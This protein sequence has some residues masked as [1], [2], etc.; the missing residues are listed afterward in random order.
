MADPQ[1]EK[2]DLGVG[3][4]DDNDSALDD[5]DSDLDTSHEKPS[6]KDATGQAAGDD[7][8]DD[9]FGEDGDD[10][11]DA[12]EAIERFGREL[13]D[14]GKFRE[15][16]RRGLGRLPSLQRDMQT[17]KEAISGYELLAQQFSILVEALGPSLDD[18]PRQRLATLI[19]Q[20]RI[21]AAVAKRT[22]SR[23]S[24]PRADDAGDAD[25]G[26]QRGSA[27]SAAVASALVHAYARGRG[28]DADSIPANVWGR[29]E[30]SA[31]G[32]YG[33]ATDL[34]Y[35]VVDRVAE[36]ASD[37]R[38][39]RKAAGARQEAPRAAGGALT[40]ETME[41]MS[42]AEVAKVPYDDFVKAMES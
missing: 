33:K 10:A 21:D 3:A 13:G 15:E 2:T 19:D 5:P 25:R 36:R 30:R 12:R 41:K 1:D 16:T 38:K 40:R 37:G 28:V 39:E 9:L 24:E 7:L 26:Q 11:F 14:L 34:M 32:D 8:F 4:G 18:G 29:A 6:D 27:D 42:P 23:R 22:D 17:V 35:K 31:G 20:A